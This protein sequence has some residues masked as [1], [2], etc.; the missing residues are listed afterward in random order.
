MDN[1]IDEKIIIDLKKKIDALIQKG[2]ELS[3]NLSV[4]ERYDMMKKVILEGVDKAL[5]NTKADGI[6]DI[7]EEEFN[8]KK[9]KL[10]DIVRE[11]FEEKFSESLA[12][13]WDESKGAL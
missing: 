12:M 4:D 6:D 9:D 8:H 2:N 10:I 7:T 3:K 1:T 11:Y 13:E 5:S